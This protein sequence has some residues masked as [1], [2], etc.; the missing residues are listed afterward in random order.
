MSIFETI[1]SQKGIDILGYNYININ[2]TEHYINF[3]CSLFFI[4]TNWNDGTQATVKAKEMK[5]KITHTL[6]AKDQTSKK[7]KDQE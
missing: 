2:T 5:K 3:C 6:H 4:S 1:A 7:I